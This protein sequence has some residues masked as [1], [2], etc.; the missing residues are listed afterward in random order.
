M[1]NP[2]RKRGILSIFLVILLLVFDAVGAFSG[3]HHSLQSSADNTTPTLVMEDEIEGTDLAAE[4]DSEGISQVKWE[5]GWVKYNGEIYRYKED[6]LTFLIMGTD[7]MGEN[8]AKSGGLDGGQA[9]LLILAVID[10]ILKR[11]EFIPINRNTMVDVDVYDAAG[12]IV[13]TAFAQIS[14]QHGV[15]DGEAES[16]EYQAKAVSRY[17]YQLP[18][19]GY[20][21]MK[22]DGI[23][24][25][26][27]A[28]GGVDLTIP[29]DAVTPS[30]SYKKGEEVHLEGNDAHLF[31]RDR[32]HE[33]GGSDRRL[34]RQKVFLKALMNKVMVTLKSNP[35]SVANI[36]SAVA[37][38]I[39]TDISLDEMLYIAGQCGGYTFDS[40]SFRT[41]EGE[42]VEGELYDEF[43]PDTDKVKELM[44]SVFYEKVDNNA[45][46]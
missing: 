7:Q 41:I 43:Y 15:G 37:P 38:Y 30:F 20:I 18:I 14:V 44:I 9:D 39:T 10:P 8:K 1:R 12:N 23:G 22:M 27:E 29:E 42:T 25:L 45:Q 5:D 6:V 34:E 4:P 46:G 40:N 28:V 24:P 33:L 26:S 17:L 21:S 32:D 35:T 11:I 31:V 3:G 2:N 16:C 13:R 36:Y 19:H